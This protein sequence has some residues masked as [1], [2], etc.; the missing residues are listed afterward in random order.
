MTTAVGQYATL[1]GVQVRLGNSSSADSAELQV[2][3][4]Q[5]NA[6]IEQATGRVLAPLPAVT[7]TLAA[8]VAAGATTITVA[9]ASDIA[10][11]AV[12]DELAI[13]PV[14]GAHESSA[15]NAISGTT[16]TLNV[17][18]AAAY[19]SGTAVQRVYLRD[20]MDAG[21]D[22]DYT[23]GRILV[24]QRGVVYLTA[25]EIAP[26]TRAEFAVIPLTDIWLRPVA[27]ERQPGWPATELHM[28]NVPSPGNPY[29]AFFPGYANVR[30]WGQLG[31]PAIPTDIAGIAERAV[32]G[33]WQMRAGGGAYSVG[34][35]TDTAQAIPHLLSVTDWRTIQ[36]YRVK[37]VKVL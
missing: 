10:N 12:G 6:W 24:E 2:F 29:P 13:G 8:D 25:L 17:A 16:V 22:G 31:W 9:Q 11:L 21:S 4:D 5:V 7:S 27:S 19:S 3:C 33:L 15:V 20:G 37:A 32:V 34:P 28:T 14:T 26:Y 1:A 35:G 30:L 23:S 18:L 36:A